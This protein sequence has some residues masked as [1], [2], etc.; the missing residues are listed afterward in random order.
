M[1]IRE[2]ARCVIRTELQ[3]DSIDKFGEAL[4]LGLSHLEGN[5]WHGALQ[6]RKI[7]EKYQIVNSVSLEAGVSLARY[8]QNGKFIVSTQDNGQVTIFDEKLNEKMVIAAHDDIVSSLSISLQNPNL[9]ATVG[10]DGAICVWDMNSDHVNNPTFHSDGLGIL[11]D[12]CFH[13]L[14][15]TICCSVGKDGNARIWD[16]RTL[17][18]E[19]S[20]V[21]N[22]PQI[23]SSVIWNPSDSHQIVAGME[24]GTIMLLDQRHLSTSIFTESL[25]KSRIRRLRTFSNDHNQNHTIF[26]TSED[27]TSCAF[28]M[29][30]LNQMSTQITNAY[31]TLHRYDEKKTKKLFF[32]FFFYYYYYFFHK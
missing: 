11:N 7:D 1:I 31:D 16:T 23:C 24:D 30:E 20:Q 3:I 26:S 18:N 8:S 21:Y 27:N 2:N 15:T 5:N 32:L 19:S 28:K 9:I 22:M 13:P 17:S 12:V 14:E 10:W 6:T 4:L 25:H 29:N